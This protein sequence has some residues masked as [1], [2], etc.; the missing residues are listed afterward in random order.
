MEN[1]SSEDRTVRIHADVPESLRRRLRH[2]AID[3]GVSFGALSA[4]L[5]MAG[6]EATGVELD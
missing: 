5:L 1:N 3:R 4:E 6:I 2:V